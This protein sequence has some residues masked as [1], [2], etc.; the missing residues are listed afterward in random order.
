[1]RTKSD[2]IE[3]LVGDE[4]DE[5]IKELFDSLLQKYQKGLE[6]SKRGSEFVFDSVDLL[7]YRFHKISLNRGGSYI[8]YIYPKNNNDNC[9]QYA[10]T[11]ALH[12]QD[13]KYNSERLSKIKPFIDKYNWKKIEFSSHKRDWRMFESN[14]KTIAFSVL[15]V[16]HNREKIKRA[17]VSKHNLTRENQI[18]SLMIT[19]GLIL[20]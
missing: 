19:D 13:I 11:V 15:Y 4:T 12:H 3:I 16:S 5:I 18:F 8:D 2:N 17:Y 14:Y 7:Y 9:L 6:E 10:I 1:M 20:L